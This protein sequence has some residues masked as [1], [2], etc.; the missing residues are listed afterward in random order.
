M[1]EKTEQED[2]WSTQKGAEPQRRAKGGAKL[3]CNVLSMGGCLFDV[4]N[5]SMHS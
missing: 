3:I 5:V 2:G 1:R 4:V